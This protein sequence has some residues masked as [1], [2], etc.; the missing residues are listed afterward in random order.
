MYFSNIKQETLSYLIFT[1]LQYTK[2][3]QKLH[4]YSFS[5][6]DRFK[7]YSKYKRPIALGYHDL[8]ITKLEFDES[9]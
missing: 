8:R 6:T 7:K 4:N 1:L 3:K 9:D 5:Q 2:S